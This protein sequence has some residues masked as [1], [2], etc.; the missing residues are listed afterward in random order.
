MVVQRSRI[1]IAPHLRYGEMACKA[2][3]RICVATI[4]LLQA[5]ALFRAALNAPIRVN[6]GYRTEAENRRVGGSSRSQHLFGR[7]MDIT[8]DG[9]DPFDDQT[10]RM[11]LRSGFIGI[12]RASNWVHVDVRPLSS[13]DE[14]VGIFW[15]YGARGARGSDENMREIARRYHESSA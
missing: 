5:W 10:P 3:P 9:C 14:A 8:W 11:L 2:A 7:A 4:E 15:K 6:S 12:G 1:L 13:G